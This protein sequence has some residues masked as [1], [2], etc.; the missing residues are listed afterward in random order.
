M[1]EKHSVYI[2]S[3]DDRVCLSLLLDSRFPFWIYRTG[4]VLKP[5][6]EES[7]GSDLSISRLRQPFFLNFRDVMRYKIA[8]LLLI[9]RKKVETT[10][11]WDRWKSRPE[12][13]RHV[14][15]AKNRRCSSQ[16]NLSIVTERYFEY[17]M[18]SHYKFFVCVKHTLK[19]RS[20]LLQISGEPFT[21]K[22]N[23]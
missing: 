4:S 19:A 15:G 3:L 6:L 22:K 2:L 17:L 10:T 11:G 1:N 9:S 23:R 20:L 16:S 14:S 13:H 7:A 12:D 8:H 18:I 5:Q 21:R